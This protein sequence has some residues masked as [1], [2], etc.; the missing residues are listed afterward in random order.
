MS[1]S[2]NYSKRFSLMDR[3]GG[4][5]PLEALIIELRSNG[6]IMKQEVIM[7]GRADL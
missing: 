7:H 1:I 6:I 4:F 5:S 2:S 3:D